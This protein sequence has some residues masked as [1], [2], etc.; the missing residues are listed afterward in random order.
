MQPLEQFFRE[1]E[2]RAVRQQQ[3]SHTSSSPVSQSNQIAF[4]QKILLLKHS[5]LQ[6][7]KACQHYNQTTQNCNLCR[8]QLSSKASKPE[9][10]CPIGKW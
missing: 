10:R 3:T 2:R 7:C 9:A 4:E 6:I 5:R 8:C 1:L